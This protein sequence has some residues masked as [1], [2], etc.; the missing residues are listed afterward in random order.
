MQ[1]PFLAPSLPRLRVRPAASLELK[2][3]LTSLGVELA[4]DRERAD[5]TAAANPPSPDDRLS[6]SQVFHQAFVRVDEEGTEAAAA[7][8]V[9]MTRAGGMR[10]LPEPVVVLADHPFL[11]LLRDAKTGAWLFMGRVQRPE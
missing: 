4:F 2:A 3:V 1:P 8:A 11:F 10:T 9:L 5:F 6:I 7:T